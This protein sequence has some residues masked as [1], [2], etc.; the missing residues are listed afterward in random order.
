LLYLRT[1]QTRVVSSL[2]W[3]ARAAMKGGAPA[4]VCR[5]STPAPQTGAAPP[6]L[7]VAKNTPGP[8]NLEL[9]T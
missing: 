9:F 5:G 8:Q 1:V 4:W 6:R 2:E 3:V 7:L